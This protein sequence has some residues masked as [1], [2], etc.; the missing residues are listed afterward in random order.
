MFVSVKME[1]IHPWKV[2]LFLASLFFFF[3]SFHDWR[4]KQ[5]LIKRW[6]KQKVHFPARSRYSCHPLYSVE[7]S[8]TGGRTRERKKEKEWVKK[9][10]RVNE[11][12]MSHNHCLLAEAALDK[13]GE[14]THGQVPTRKEMD[15]SRCERWRIW[16][17][18]ACSR[19][20][21]TSSYFLRHHPHALVI[22]SSLRGLSTCCHDEP[23]PCFQIVIH[24]SSLKCFLLWV[25][26]VAFVYLY[27]CSPKYFAWI[28]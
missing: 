14:A 4:T 9:K 18:G 7:P 12:K 6:K 24:L 28:V 5:Q 22:I 13:C 2:L 1:P 27:I 23:V 11:G 17:Q 8:R 26:V 3:F 21:H 20:P 15:F 25:I 19:T 16:W 10:K